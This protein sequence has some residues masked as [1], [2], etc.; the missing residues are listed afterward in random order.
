MKR[1]IT[2]FTLVIAVTIAA[3][4]T[5]C[6]DV[7]IKGYYISGDYIKTEAEIILDGNG[8][9]ST[10]KV[11]T[12][13]AW[14]FANVPS[15]ITVTPMSG[16]GET[17]VIIT[18][19]DNPSATQERTGQ[20]TLRTSNQERIISLTQKTAHEF[21]ESDIITLTF[22]PD[23]GTERFSIRS[24]TSWSLNL[25]GNFFSVTPTT[26]SENTTFTVI[27]E[28]NND[29]AQRMG[30]IDIVG[31]DS[32]L[33]IPVAQLGITRTLTLS[34]ENI[35]VDPI[36]NN[37]SITLNGDAPWTAKSSVEWASVEQLSG[38][39][40][41]TVNVSIDEN[42][43]TSQRTAII[44]FE[45]SKKSISCQITQRAGSAP[46]FTSPQPT[47]TNVGK[48]SATV[49]A[50]YTSDFDVTEYG[51]CYS[52]TNSKP[53][54]EDAHANRVGS[55]KE[56]SFSI[57]LDGL[58]SLTTYYVTVYARNKVGITYSTYTTF[59]TTGGIPNEDDV[60]KP[61]L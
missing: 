23:G 36:A 11:V 5:A 34:P 60:I 39:G 41:G 30:S 6:S 57:D 8:K 10:Y 16:S 54:I 17:D 48:Y 58:K 9:N 52:E 3:I 44:T 45:T 46:R 21:F 29:E 25:T 59:T 2:Y 26:G 43:T 56:G 50:S 47:I 22:Q 55:A 35:T 51:V 18:P 14:S 15:W 42:A 40:S 7:D 33:R 4:V 13:G 24:N 53:T 38:T 19:K 1:T 32:I 31:R 27:C 61:N 28:I 12:N 37:V 49:S 20:M